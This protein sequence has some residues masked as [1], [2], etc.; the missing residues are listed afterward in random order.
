MIDELTTVTGAQLEQIVYRL[1]TSRWNFDEDNVY[2]VGQSG[3]YGVDVLATDDTEHQIGVQVKAYSNS[4]GLPAVQQIVAAKAMYGF[5]EG[6]VVT[7]NV[8]TKNAHRLARANNIRVIEGQE[9]RR[10]VYE[11]NGRW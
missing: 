5:D 10:L 8:L 4:V 6:W 3:D 9:L 1:F 7:N 11:M 2:L